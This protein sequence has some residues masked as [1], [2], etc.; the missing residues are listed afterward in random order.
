LI[1]LAGG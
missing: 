1:P